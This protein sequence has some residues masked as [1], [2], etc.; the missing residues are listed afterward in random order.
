MCGNNPA[1]RPLPTLRRWI[2][3]RIKAIEFDPFDRDG[4][5]QYQSVLNKIKEME[6]AKE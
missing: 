2:E 5:A 1:D 6:S 3:G 4:T